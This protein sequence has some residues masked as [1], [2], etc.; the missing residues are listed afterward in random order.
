MLKNINPLLTPELLRAMAAMGHG[1][2]LAVVD[3]NF[4]P[5]GLCCH[6][7][8]ERG[9][10]PCGR[11]SGALGRKVQGTAM[12]R[13]VALDTYDVRFPALQMLYSSDAILS[14][15]AMGPQR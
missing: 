1:G 2:K 15:R 4:P 10:D 6:R 14:A 11:A 3:A 7:L 8:G 13:V 5:T 9:Q 12:T